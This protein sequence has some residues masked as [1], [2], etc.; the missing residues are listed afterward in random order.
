MEEKEHGKLK[1]IF[2]I[3]FPI[4][5]IVIFGAF[6]LNFLGIP[7]GKTLQDWGN[8]LPVINYIIPDSAPKQTLNVDGTNDWKQK[9]LQDEQVLK[10]QDQQIAELNKELNSNQKGDQNLKKSIIALQKQLDTKQTQKYQDQMNKIA[11]IYGNMSPSKAAAILESMSLGDASTT[12]SLLNQDQQSSILGSMKDAKKAASITMM[13]KEIASLTETDQAALNA[14]IQDLA[15]K[16]ENPTKTLA[17]TIA[18]MPPTQS[19]VIIKSMMGSNPQVAMEL[20][21]NVTTDSRSQI[22]AAIAN[23]DV[24]L[25]AQITASLN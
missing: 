19:A 14:Q 22:L 5:F 24:K 7:V 15:L 13:L 3:C 1:A 8:K 10:E 25:A 2:Y 9:Y 18:G 21:K 6:I 23:T 16:Q 11:G 20:M 17:Q 12:V 4:L